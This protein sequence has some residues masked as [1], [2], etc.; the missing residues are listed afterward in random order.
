MSKI[1][2]AG[3]TGRV[4]R[5]VVDVL[6]AQ[7]HDVVRISRS[8]GV[9]AI[10]AE[11]LAEA[12]E[13]VECVVDAASWPTSEQ[14]PATEFFITSAANLQAYGERAG[15]QRIVM[16]SIIGADRFSAG[17]IASKIPH[18]RAHLTGPIP[19]RVLRAAQF[20]EFVELLM[21]W[22]R[23]D[24]VIHVP[25]MRTQLVAA[26]TVAAALATSPPP[27]RSRRST[28]RRSGRSP[29][30][31]RRTSSRSRGWSWPAAATRSGSR[32]CP[33]PPT[34]IATSTSPAA[35]SRARTPHSKGR[36]SRHGWSRACRPDAHAD[37]HAHPDRVMIG[38]P[39]GRDHRPTW[40]RV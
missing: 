37:A 22:G 2:V 20:H 36:R 16:V 1:A 40:S 34:R 8:T 31:A 11:G 29:A 15:V 26:R 25:R 19:A 5:H 10:T 30:R 39:G 6:E 3:A 9:D 14:E 7:G 28:T 12:L 27:S 23:R 4:G 21:A 24:D 17:Y 38:H 18:E 13:G 33:T 32:A 35:C